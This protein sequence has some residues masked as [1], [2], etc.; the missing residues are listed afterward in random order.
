MN[1]GGDLRQRNPD[2]DRRKTPGLGS[3]SALP[4]KPPRHPGMPIKPRVP[5]RSAKTSSA[6]KIGTPNLGAP[7]IPTNPIGTPTSPQV[8]KPTVPLQPGEIAQFD[9]LA[10]SHQN[11]DDVADKEAGNKLKEKLIKSVGS[12]ATGRLLGESAKEFFDDASESYYHEKSKHKKHPVRKTA[13]KMFVRKLL[14]FS[15]WGVLGV[16][17]GMGVLLFFFAF[18]YKPEHVKQYLI[19]VHL[20]RFNLQLARRVGQLVASEGLVSAESTG[21]LNP[22]RRGGVTDLLVGYNPQSALTRLGRADGIEL[23]MKSRRKWNLRLTNDFRGYRNLTTGR[24][25]LLPENATRAQKMAAVK[26]LEEEILS[27]NAMRNK[28]WRG[29]LLLDIRR[30]LKLRLIRFDDLGRIFKGK[31]R[32]EALNIDQKRQ[33]LAIRDPD[34]VVSLSQEV[35]DETKRNQDRIKNGDF[36]DEAADAAGEAAVPQRTRILERIIESFKARPA[37]AILRGLS[38]LNAVAVTICLLYDA[39]VYNIEKVIEK[40]SEN[41]ARFSYSIFN[42]ADQQKEGDVT[43]KAV[44]A[45]VDSLGDFEYSTEY[46]SGLGMASKGEKYDMP[47]E[48]YPQKA[49]GESPE[50]IKNILETSWNALGPKADFAFEATCRAIL[51]Y[52]GQAITSL[53]E[54]LLAI[55]SLSTSEVVAQGVWQTMKLAIKVLGTT[56]VKSGGALT[57]QILMTDWLMP[58]MVEAYSGSD[59]ASQEE[60]SAGFNKAGAGTEIIGLE[61]DKQSGAMVL[62]PDQINEYSAELNRIQ[63]E[64]DSTRSWYARIFDTGNIRSLAA[65]FVIRVPTSLSEVRTFATT[66]LA[67]ISPMNF[68]HEKVISYSE[69]SQPIWAASGEGPYGIKQFGVPLNLFDKC[70]DDESWCPRENAKIVEPQYDAL[71]AKYGKCFKDSTARMIVRFNSSEYADCF[72]DG[73]D[74]LQKSVIGQRFVLYKKDEFI[75]RESTSLQ[76]EEDDSG[77]GTGAAVGAAVGNI[78]GGPAFTTSCSPQPGS[79]ALPAPVPAD[80]NAPGIPIVEPIISRGNN[81]VINRG[82][83]Q[84]V[85]QCVQNMISDAEDAGVILSGSGF[86]DLA[87]QLRAGQANGCPPNWTSSSQCRVPT[88]PVGRSN[89]GWGVAIDFNNCRYRSTAC[90]QW[91]AANSTNYGFQN[92]PSEPWHWSI[93]GN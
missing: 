17:A 74:S 51:S 66:A 20:A 19:D 28:I 39:Y 31:N 6:P 5:F 77:L 56:V 79:P 7:N 11:K 88:A 45:C 18:L 12:Q 32:V 21:R 85:A 29:K 53:V 10:T 57:V 14:G 22:I 8:D 42:C 1:Q 68:V 83:R 26:E 92:L 37:F 87:G 49:M 75:L 64:K 76:N 54:F 30:Q 81:A 89:H 23:V 91:L 4:I 90:Y 48:L 33:D 25:Y 59:N 36:T 52:I 35:D 9:Q 43:S 71:E 93:N 41:Y 61:M 44:Q 63:Y 67:N 34:R 47:E 62:T 24:E 2:K 40:R 58:R 38:V 70:I 73:G 84:D 69:R 15:V 82:V 86:R 72:G 13:R 46:R 55:W 80:G 50:A 16:V 78:G 27:I 3:D 60:A 65:Q